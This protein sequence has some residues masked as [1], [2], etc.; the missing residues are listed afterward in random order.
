[1]SPGGSRSSLGVMKACKEG[2]VH[3]SHITEPPTCTIP[4]QHRRRRPRVRR[5]SSA[6]PARWYRQ[7]RDRR[8]RRLIEL[9]VVAAGV[10]VDVVVIEAASLATAPRGGPHRAQTRRVGGSFARP[11]SHCPRRRWTGVEPP[12][13]RRREGQISERRPLRK[14][15]IYKSLQP[16]RWGSLRRRHKSEISSDAPEVVP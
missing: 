3:R 6:A 14:S 11:P 13:V 9:V 5:P 15:Q 1:M 10:V 4:S 8:N 7:R 12:F 16:V 2:E